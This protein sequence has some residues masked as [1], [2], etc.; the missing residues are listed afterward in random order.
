MVEEEPS[1]ALTTIRVS[2]P[3]G[4]GYTVYS[5]GESKRPLRFTAI[6]GIVVATDGDIDK[7]F[8]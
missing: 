2:P 8:N 1:S 4:P 7:L 6:E 3:I 5:E